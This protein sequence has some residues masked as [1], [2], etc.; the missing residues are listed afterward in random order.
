M[1]E[2]V[3]VKSVRFYDKLGY[4]HHVEWQC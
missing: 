1:L 2:F 4:E 3:N